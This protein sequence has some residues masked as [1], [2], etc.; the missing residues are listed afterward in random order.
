M[1]PSLTTASQDVMHNT[2]DLD[3]EWYLMSQTNY[4][5]PIYPTM[6]TELDTTMGVLNISIQTLLFLKCTA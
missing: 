3:L 2:E 1:S 6:L 5:D 4:L